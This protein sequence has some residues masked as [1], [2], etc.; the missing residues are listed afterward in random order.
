M[1]LVAVVILWPTFVTDLAYGLASN[2]DQFLNWYVIIMVTN[3]IV[4]HMLHVI[5][6]IILLFQH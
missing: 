4:L 3:F 1:F 2:V 6:A 5:G